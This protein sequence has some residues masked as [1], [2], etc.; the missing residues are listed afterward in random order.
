MH[1]HVKTHHNGQIP[2]HKHIQIKALEKE[3]ERLS[4][5]LGAKQAK[6]IAVKSHKAMVTASKGNGLLSWIGA[7]ATVPNQ[8]WAY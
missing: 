6:E 7:D 3:K 4:K 1:T 2:T 8:R 5:V